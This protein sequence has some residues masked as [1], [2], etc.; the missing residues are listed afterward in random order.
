MDKQQAALNYMLTLV[1]DGWEF[2]DAAYRAASCWH[3]QQE[4]LEAEYDALE[5]QR[6]GHLFDQYA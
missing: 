2:P 1:D 5:T 4:R 3:V 6:V